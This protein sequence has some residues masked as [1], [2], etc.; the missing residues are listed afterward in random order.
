MKKALNIIIIICILTTMIIIGAFSVSA[1]NDYDWKSY[2]PTWYPYTNMIPY[3]VEFKGTD[4]YEYR[5]YF[6]SGNITLDYSGNVLTCKNNTS[7]AI[8][9]Y[10]Y[11]L[12]SPTSVTAEYEYTINGNGTAWL[13][14]NF[15]SSNAI[16][17]SNLSNTI[18]TMQGIK[19]SPTTTKLGYIFGQSGTP[20]AN[21]YKYYT[22]LLASNGRACYI[23][24]DSNTSMV[25]MY[26][27]DLEYVRVTGTNMSIKMSYNYSSDINV[28]PGVGN[29][30]HNFDFSWLVGNSSINVVFSNM[31]LT[32]QNG[33]FVEWKSMT[34]S[35]A[36]GLKEWDESHNG[37]FDSSKGDNSIGDY[38]SATKD[39][40]NKKVDI[41]AN[42]ID[43]VKPTILWT[44]AIMMK[45]INIFPPPLISLMSLVMT[46]GIIVLALGMVSGS[47]T[48]LMDKKD[49]EK[50]KGK[51]K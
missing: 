37:E 28:R 47:A 23:M 29:G 45:I 34:E 1:D 46:I 13:T 41:N 49:K 3:A 35:V 22:V 40:L 18:G 2:M 42:F 32:D 14:Y 50:G 12:S 21:D 16:M 44:S 4:G 19:K 25:N 33:S 7:T 8:K 15:D 9:Y 6:S 26:R 48:D 10:M 5:I 24:T 20:V 43:S 17:S 27:K 51:D 39:I 36:D 38:E 30:Q 31:K 11:V